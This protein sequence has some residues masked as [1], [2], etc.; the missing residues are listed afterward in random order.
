MLALSLLKFY[1]AIIIIN[2]HQYLFL[3]YQNL[4]FKGRQLEQEMKI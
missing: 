4:N 2:S 1:I 3:T